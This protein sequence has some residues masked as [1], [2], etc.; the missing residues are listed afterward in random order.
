[1]SSFEPQAFGKYFLV[2]KIATGG[3]AEIFKAKTFSHGGFEN[4]VVIKRILG[5]LSENEEFVEMFVDEAKVSVSLQHANIVRVYDFGKVLSNYFIAMECVDGK[6]IRVILRKLAKERRY[7][8]IDFALYIAHEV[9]RGLDYAHSKTDLRGHPYGIVHRDMSPS[10]VL[11]SYEGDVKI[12]DFG[13]AKAEQNTYDTAEGVLKGKFEYMSPEQARGESVDSRS[14]LFAVGI[15]LYE[16]L[17]GRRL[18]K[19]ESDIQT[20]ERIKRCDFSPPS[21]VTP[22]VPASIERVVLKLLARDPDER[23]ARAAQALA[24][25]RELLGRSPDEIRPE[26]QVFLRDL[27]TEEITEELARFEAGSAIADAWRT[28]SDE[29]VWDGNSTAGASTLR[30]TSRKP[31]AL[32]PIMVLLLLLLMV[33][34]TL[35]SAA[36]VSFVLLQAPTPPPAE[37]STPSPGSLSVTVLPAAAIYVDGKQVGQGTT[38]RL[39]GLEPRSYA[40]RLVADGREPFL[41]DVQIEP[42]EIASVQHT[43]AP[44]EP[45]PAEPSPTRDSP[46]SP[47][48]VA[49]APSLVFSTTPSGATVVIDGQDVGKTPMTWTAEPDTAYQIELRLSGHEPE[50]VSVQPLQAGAERAVRRSLSPV[51]V[52]EPGTLVVGIL[53]GGWGHVFIDGEKQA[54]AAPGRYPIRPGAREVRVVNEELQLDY[55]E[56]VQVKDGATIRVNARP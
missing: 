48:A 29:S 53:G 3:M 28:T 43:F 16:M 10:N 52:E 23:Y 34:G 21:K 46:R 50:R 41:T 2:D 35:L 33:G 18:F 1:M 45:G 14:D 13:I 49:P 26:L 40:V 39:D 4:L 8:P 6:D 22:R 24:D 19:G 7:L 27:F 25:I 15:L 31:R 20:L 51:A 11:V 56:S 37:P 55:H 42:G 30:T 54:K 5:H 44:P 17:T 47:R 12:A 38:V 9:C 32:W 36:G